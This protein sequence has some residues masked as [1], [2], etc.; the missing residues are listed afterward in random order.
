MTSVQFAFVKLIVRDLDTM[1]EFYRRAL[2]LYPART[3]EAGTATEIVMRPEGQRAGFCLVLYRHADGR[4]VV[5]G[6]GHGPI[7]L[8]VENTDD[9]FTGALR[10][11]ASPKQ[12]PFDVAGLRVAFVEDP[13]GHELEFLQLTPTSRETE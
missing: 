1:T 13:E 6:T 8:Y 7:G 11:G 9:A 4:I 12:A 3:I 2:G 5:V 10:A